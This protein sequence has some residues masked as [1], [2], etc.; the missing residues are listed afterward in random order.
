MDANIPANAAMFGAPVALALAPICDIIM[1]PIIPP[2]MV[3]AA[4]LLFYKVKSQYSHRMQNI[5]EIS[6]TKF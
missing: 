6:K 3:L 2:N 4:E 1:F 5:K